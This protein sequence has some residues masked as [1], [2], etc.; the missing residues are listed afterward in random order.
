MGP[1]KG[2]QDVKDTIKRNQN[3]LKRVSDEVDRIQAPKPVAP[4]KGGK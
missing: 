4:K 1:N 3:Q 2:Q